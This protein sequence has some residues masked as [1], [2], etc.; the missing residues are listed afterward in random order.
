MHCLYQQITDSRNWK[1][2]KLTN[3]HICWDLRSCRKLDSVEW[4]ILTDVSEQP[5]G[6]IF[7]GQAVQGEISDCLTAVLHKI[8][9]DRRSHLHCGRSL[10]SRDVFLAHKN[11]YFQGTVAP[12]RTQTPR[13]QYARVEAQLNARAFLSSEKEPP[14]NQWMW[15]GLGPKAET[16]PVEKRKNLLPLPGIELLFLGRPAR[17]H[18]LLWLAYSRYVNETHTYT[19][20]MT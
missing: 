16:D 10:E 20:S 11:M 6:P 1:T 13:N 9:K 14:G 7:K 2:Y 5:I 12:V 4:Q 19:T 3:D 18:Q 8:P 17:R 15:G